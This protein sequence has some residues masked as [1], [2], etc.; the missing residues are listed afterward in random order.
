MDRWNDPDPPPYPTQINQRCE[1]WGL[2][3]TR[4]RA[5]RSSRY[6]PEWNGTE[7]KTFMAC[8]VSVHLTRHHAAECEQQ[9]AE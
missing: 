6:R 8:L 2:A 4:R 5:K 7:R 9:T 3:P 1:K